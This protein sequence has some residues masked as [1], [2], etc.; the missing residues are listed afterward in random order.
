MCP[1]TG[2]LQILL[3][4]SKMEIN[5]KPATIGQCPSLTCILGKCMEHIIVSSIST[6][7]DTNKILNPLQHG[8]RK[9]LSRDSQLLSLFHDLASGPAETDLIVMDF[10][11]S[12]DKVPHRRL[13][14]KL[15]WYR[16]RCGTLDWITCFLTDR[17]QKVVLDGAE[18]LPGPV[19]SLVSQGS[20][21]GPIL[22]LI[23]I[24]DLPDGVTHSPSVL[25]DRI[26][27]RLV[28]DKNDI[29]WL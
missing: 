21:L 8:F 12:F 28:T 22:L 20:V 25:S 26:L 29:N 15:E 5:I 6:H 14:Y 10:S 9:R 24:N 13:L 27:Y 4:S 2:K 11:K 3:S 7:L 17:T 16:I 1:V 18:S 23:Y 19:L